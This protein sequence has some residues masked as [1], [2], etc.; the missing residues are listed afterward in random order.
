MQHHK[1]LIDNN[2]TQVGELVVTQGTALVW[3]D[4]YPPS[5][6]IVDPPL[7]DTETITLTRHEARWLSR[8]LADV[9]NEMERKEIERA[10]AW[11]G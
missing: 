5:S 2:G 10:R 8:V 11:M 9:A 1:K 7:V 4:L 3:V 6:Q